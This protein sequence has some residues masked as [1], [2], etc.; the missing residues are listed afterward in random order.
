[1]PKVDI[2]L[3]R[4]GRPNFQHGAWI[5]PRELGEWVA[6]Y[7]AAAIAGG[8]PPAAAVQ[9]AAPA[10]IVSSPTLRALE[11]ARRLAPDR[12]I[13]TYELFR[14]ADLPH[15]SWRW[16][17]LPPSL[18]VVLF[19][20]AWLGGFSPRTES[21]SKATGRAGEAADKLIALARGADSVLLVGHG[22]MNSMIAKQL[23]ARGAR[24]PRFTGSR[25]WDITTYHL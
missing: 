23:L 5:A 18:W 20:L 15:L 19:R 21:V 3:A 2:L 11:S 4:H 17:R 13:R 16:P 24:G 10:L 7:D 25:Y 12:E 1:L 14:E 9:S 22:V 6:R 8:E